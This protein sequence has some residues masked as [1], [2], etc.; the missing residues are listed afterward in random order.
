[1]S[2]ASGFN[3]CSPLSEPDIDQHSSLEIVSPLKTLQVYVELGGDE[4]S[5]EWLEEN[6]SDDS[7]FNFSDTFELVKEGGD[8]DVEMGLISEMG[9]PEA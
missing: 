2:A 8:G 5:F 7:T 9:S 4:E 1:M 3:R 6:T